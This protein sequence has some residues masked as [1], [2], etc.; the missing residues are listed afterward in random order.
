[1]KLMASIEGTSSRKE[2]RED[3]ERPSRIGM[4]RSG[5]ARN[6]PR[7]TAVPGSAIALRSREAASGVGSETTGGTR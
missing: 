4:P 2:R 6:A 7:K 1:M 5:T 3:R